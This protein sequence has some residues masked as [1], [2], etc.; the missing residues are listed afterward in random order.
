MYAGAKFTCGTIYN[1]VFFNGSLRYR[2]FPFDGGRS[3]VEAQVGAGTAPEILFLKYYQ[4]SSVFNHLNSFVACTAQWA[5]T[6]NLAIQLSGTWN[7][8]YD[9][10]ATVSYRNLLMVHVSL[11]ISF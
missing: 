5:I 9:Q 10:R 6:H 11:A 4:T 7:T 3:Y 2:F 1:I 8:L